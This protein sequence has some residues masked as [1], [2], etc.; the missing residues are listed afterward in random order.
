MYKT[1]ITTP[2]FADINTQTFE[3]PN[4]LGFPFPEPFEERVFSAGWGN[5]RGDPDNK[6]MFMS[7]R[8]DTNRTIAPTPTTQ[9]DPRFD[10][11][12]NTRQYTQ[13][14]MRI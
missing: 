11:T 12:K 14:V 9:F 3:G 4:L 6:T 1:R 10:D 2:Y 8:P 7:R 5:V 13:G